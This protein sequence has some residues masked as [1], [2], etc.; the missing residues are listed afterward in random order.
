MQTAR[1][2][3]NTYLRVQIMNFSSY[4]TETST[5]EFGLAF[6]KLIAGI[7]SNSES[8]T[9]RCLATRGKDSSSAEMI[10]KQN[11]REE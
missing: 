4:A 3:S 7:D 9:L 8:S 10:Q 2:I 6:C 5:N 1:K 11:V